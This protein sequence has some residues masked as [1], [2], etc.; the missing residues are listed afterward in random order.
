VLV[1]ALHAGI[2]FTFKFMFFSYYIVNL[3]PKD[4]TG[5][6]PNSPA[7]TVTAIVTAS[8]RAMVARTL[9]VSV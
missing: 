5:E 6:T 4:P 8:S 2:A 9:G 3:G 1:A 7:A